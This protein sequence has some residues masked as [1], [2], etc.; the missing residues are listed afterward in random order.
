MKNAGLFT[1][2]KAVVF[3]DF[4]NSNDQVEET[5]LAFSEEHINDIAVFRASGIG[6]GK[7]NHPVV[8]GGKGKIA[9]LRLKIT[10]PFELV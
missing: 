7:I 1:G 8:I 4:T 6:H 9:D 5:L 3:A 10:S 2:A